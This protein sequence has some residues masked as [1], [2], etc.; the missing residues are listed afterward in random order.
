M[1]LQTFDIE[2]KHKTGEKVTHEF[3]SMRR[4]LLRVTKASQLQSVGEGSN[5]NSY[6]GKQGQDFEFS[7]LGSMKVEFVEAV[8]KGGENLTPI[9]SWLQHLA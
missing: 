5:N 6:L 1:P 3:I 2:S 9:T 8:A 7:H 4:N